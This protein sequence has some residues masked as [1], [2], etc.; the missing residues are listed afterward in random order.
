MKLLIRYC[1]TFLI[2]L[3]FAK[4][5]ST[6]PEVVSF[7]GDTFNKETITQNARDLPVVAKA[8]IVVVGGGISGV[9]SALEAAWAGF[10]VILLE[11]RNYLGHEFTATNK[12]KTTEGSI[13][14]G[15]SSSE[16]YQEMIDKEIISGENIDPIALRS[17]LL[18]KV[19]YHP[20]IEVYFYSL[21][22][23]VIKEGDT[24][25]G[26]VFSGRS[27]RQIVLAKTVIDATE[28][29]IIV[30]AAGG[31]FSRT[32]TGENI[33]RRF[34]AIDRPEHLPVGPRAVA[35]NLG[36]GGDSIWVHNKFIELAINSEIGNDIAG[37]LSL[38]HSNTLEKSFLLKEH[39]ANDG[40]VFN[41]Y[42]PSSETWMDKV[43]LVLCKEK[44]NGDLSH[45]EAVLPT[46]IKGLVI[47]GRAVD[48]NGRTKSLQSLIKVGELSG[49]A[50]VNLTRGVTDFMSPVKSSPSLPNSS[51]TI[52]VQELLDGFDSRKYYSM[53]NQSEVKLPVNGTYDVLVIGGGTSGA[54]A[55]IAAARQGVSV[56]VVEIL[57]NMGG[58]SS[59]RVN[60]YYWGVPWK[61]F[62]RQ[63]IGDL[64]HL[65]K[66]GGTGGLEKVRFSGEDKKLALQRLAIKAGVK[67]YYQSLASGAVVK[68]NKICGVLID[69]ASGRN[70]LMANV[71]IDAT[72][73]AGIAVAAGAKYHK[74]RETDGFMNEI[75][76]GPLRDPTNLRDISTSYLRYP[77]YAVSMNIRESRRIIG[78]YVVTFDDVIHERTFDDVVCRWRSNYDTHLPTSANQSDLAQDWVGILG[79]W[80]RPI[81]GSIPYRSLLPKEVENILVAAMAYSTDHDALIGGRMQPDMEHLGE[82]AGVAAAMASKNK[83]SPRKISV[84]ELQTKLVQLGVLRDI[85]VPK[86]TEKNAPTLD[87]LHR[88][89]L[90]RTEREKVFPPQEEGKRLPVK[91]AVE[92]LGTDKALKAMVDI[93]LEGEMSIPYLKPLLNTQDRSKYEEV[94]V[95]LGLLGDD[96]AVP[97][98]LGF[99]EAR[100]TRRF[101]Y[102]LEQASSRPSLPLYWIS[103]ILLGRFEA[104]EAVPELLAILNSPPPPSEL[105]FLRRDTYGYDMFK[106]ISTC[107]PPLASFII[108]ALGR[109]GDSIA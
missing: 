85:D 11:N 54:I 22:N 73:H 63:E 49:K 66:S 23:G 46:G 86:I 104:K 51:N 91:E 14:S 36:I 8:D 52:Q 69:N 100:N 28:D 78:D 35:S 89:D 83:A 41:Q 68:G 75:E 20:K 37:D 10:S 105:S 43:P 101:E 79:L 99:L 45:F 77:S 2:F 106:N 108:V 67:I 81:I 93:Y 4:A 94:A 15:S 47:T 71:V 33:A 82:A 58:I 90:W 107:P 29:A 103:V 48:A 7:L 74:G 19:A 64:I 12:C 27:G 17:Y 34:I 84:S 44:W 76:H 42:V 18:D 98:L 109:I 61:S 59:N 13:I 70:I 38:I 53:L 72:G 26:V 5:G 30:T 32:M 96:S 56:A 21:A 60:G 9:T 16:L 24:V 92:L 88:Q 65:E 3:C 87:I 80:R 31:E 102:T 50:A 40:I 97:A 6:N 95:L 39:L 1:L 62:L 25:C 57:P 55:A